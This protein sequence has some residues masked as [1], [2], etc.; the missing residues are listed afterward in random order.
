MTWK[1]IDVGTKKNDD[2]T[3]DNSGVY[4]V[5]YR[6]DSG[7]VRADLIMVAGEPVVSYIGS[8]NNVRKALMHLLNRLP[9]GVSIQHASYIGYE[10][11]LASQTP[12]YVQE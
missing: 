9:P 11:A 8:A 2:F 10:L 4:V 6:I 12:N 5:V 1:L 7:H 3:P